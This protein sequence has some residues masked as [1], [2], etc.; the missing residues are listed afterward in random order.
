LKELIASDVRAAATRRSDGGLPIVGYSVRVVALPP[1]MTVER[2]ADSD[3]VTLDVEG[4]LDLA[5]AP[6][7]LRIATESI[8]GDADRHMV[9]RKLC[10]RFGWRLRVS[11]PNLAVRRVLELTGL[12]QYLNVE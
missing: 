11:Q 7:L 12:I 5:T 10:D 2:S 1:G 6:T 8:S 9:I 3:G 4:E